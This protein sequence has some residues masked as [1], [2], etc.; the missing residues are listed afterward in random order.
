MELTLHRTRYLDGTNGTLQYEDRTVCH[1]IELPWRQNRRTV[2]CIPE[3]RYPLL[4]RYT[5]RHR[6]HLYVA[7]VPGRS[8]IGVHP[9]N[10]ALREL[11][12]CI[13]P[14]L[15]LTGPGRGRQSQLANEVLKSLVL[16]VI[17]QEEV[18][19]T[20]TSEQC[21]TINKQKP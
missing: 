11:Q 12:G 21:E 13:A 5:A 10:D 16:P 2:S 6:L 7:G 19:L 17:H 8:D 3:G 9:A 18:W 4:A 1:T 15:E 20:I 14:V